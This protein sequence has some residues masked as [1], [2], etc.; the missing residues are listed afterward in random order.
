MKRVYPRILALLLVF[1]LLAGCTPAQAAPK[2][3]GTELSAFTIVYSE[4]QPD[5]TLRAA[6]YIQSQIKE[7][8]GLELPV[9]EA[10]SGNYEHEI[11]VGETNRAISSRLAAE[12]DNVE[13]TILADENHI[14]LEGDYF[15]IAAAAYYFVE[16][17]IPGRSFESTVPQEITVHTPITEK[18]NNFIFLI[19]DGMGFNQT[20]LVEEYDIAEFSTDSDNERIFYGNFLPHQGMIH[21]N[22]LSGI[23]DSAAAATALACGYKTIN[24]YVGKDADG[25][26]LQ[27][28]TELAASQGKATAV[29]STDQM[30]GATPAGFTAHAMD[31]DDTN[32][33]LACVQDK[34]QNG[35]IIT[36]G[37]Q[38]TASYQD[39]ISETLTE[40]EADE[41]GFFIMYE[42]GYIDKFAHKMQ[43]EGTLVSVGRFNQAIGVFMEYAFYHPD[44]FLIITADHETGGLMPNAE[45]KL[46]FNTSDHTG[47][48]VPIYGYGQGTEAFAS[49]N[50]ENTEIPK[51]IASLWGVSDF[52][53][54]SAN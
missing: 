7:R 43:I 37:L 26:D 44:T 9:C 16:T 28:L 2:L 42:E 29:L 38:A 25:N 35:T 52:G 47:S 24:H 54:Q 36:C 23:T 33:I 51:I 20:K 31:R 22:S 50:M 39:I 1:L 8:T 5:Y 21:T 30:N 10:A 32:D 15:I 6:Q 27:S 46:E 14:A 18:A 49:C 48:D 53:D 19:G 40:L 3:N 4:T 34:I 13:F 41:D 45:G 11:V 17:Y 12:T